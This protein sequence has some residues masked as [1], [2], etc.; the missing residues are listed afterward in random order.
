MID[1]FARSKESVSRGCEDCLERRGGGRFPGLWPG[2]DFADGGPG[3]DTAKPCEVTV[4]VVIILRDRIR[5]TNG[6]RPR[7]PNLMEVDSS[8]WSTRGCMKSLVEDLEAAHVG[9]F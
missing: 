3:I 4:D 1:T 8:E 6:V 9:G 5:Q 7:P 2:T